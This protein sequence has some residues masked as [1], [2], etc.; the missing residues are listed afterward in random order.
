M[1]MSDL[2]SL[3]TNQQNICDHS[4]QKVFDNYFLH[5]D[6]SSELKQLNF[7]SL[8]NQSHNSVNNPG[9]LTLNENNIE[10]F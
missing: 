6:M 5:T 3:S 1:S 7:L 4:W 9:V 10:Q 8:L 2:T